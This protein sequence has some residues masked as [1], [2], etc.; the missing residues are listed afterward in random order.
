MSKLKLNRIKVVLVENNRTSKELANHL[1]KTVSTVSRWCTN[2]A[3]PSI[4]TLYEVAKYLK[5]DIRE[6]LLSTGNKS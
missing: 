2:E 6:L 3:Q 1:G 5:V 4:E